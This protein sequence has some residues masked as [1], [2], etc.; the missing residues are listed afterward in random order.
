MCKFVTAMTLLILGSLSAMPAFAQ[1]PVSLEQGT[2]PFGS[3]YG[4]DIESVNMENGRL[5]LHIPL[6]S[7]PQRGNLHLSFSL[8]YEDPGFQESEVPNTCPPNGVKGECDYWVTF[9]VGPGEGEIA[10]VV[11][12][13][14]QNLSVS[15]D[16]ALTGQN[17]QDGSSTYP[18]EEAIYHIAS[19]DLSVH[20]LAYSNGIFRAV[21][22]SG[23]EYIPGTENPEYPAGTT[24]QNPS[25]VYTA[26]GGTVID[27]SGTRYT[28]SS[29]TGALTQIT[30]VDGN[31]MTVGPRGRDGRL[32]QSIGSPGLRHFNRADFRV[33]RNRRRFKP[34]VDRSRL[35]DAAVVRRRY[36]RPLHLLLHQR[37][38]QDRSV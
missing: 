38:H 19:S 4:T 35:L 12:V 23:Y 14:D 32:S 13:F 21:D 8:V 34:T 33:S 10:G 25:N 24:S 16:N 9:P 17:W 2:K 3:Y 5:V 37:H 1:E 29:T 6:Y 11:P 28:L 26:A 30:D 36:Y 18:Y 20:T 22:G 7:L 15:L 31:Y 27:S